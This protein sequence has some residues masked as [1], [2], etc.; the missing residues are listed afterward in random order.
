[1]IDPSFNSCNM[2]FYCGCF[3]LFPRES[4]WEAVV[5]GGL[6]NLPNLVLAGDLNL[7]LNGFE[8]WG[9][10]ALLDPLGPFFKQLF[11]SSQLLDIAPACAGP[12]WQNGRSGE[13][14][15]SKRIDIFLLSS[16][17]VDLLPWHRV[18]A[19]PSS[20]SDHY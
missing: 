9:K 20:V 12:T 4:F 19:Y 7:T 11:S 8:V 1:M 10:K 5:R 18:W 15:I 2:S 16:S 6:L 13:E 17:I 14:G 3:L